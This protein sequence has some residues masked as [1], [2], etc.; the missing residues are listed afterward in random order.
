MSHPARGAWIE[1]ALVE[2]L[3][4]GLRGRTP[5]GV[6]GLKLQGFPY[7]RRAVA[8]HPARG[9]WIETDGPSVDEL[10]SLSHPARG[11]WIETPQ[12]FPRCQQNSCRTPLGVRGLKRQNLSVVRLWPGRTPLGV[13]GLKLRRLRCPVY[14]MQSHPARGAWIETDFEGNYDARW[15]SHPARGAWI[16]TSVLSV[17]NAV[18]GSHPARGA[19]IETGDKLLARVN[20]GVAPRSGCVD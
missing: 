17:I 6:R 8:S 19:W 13:R 20:S 7:L 11:A 16:E 12:E 15:A 3:K 10:R 5:L 14:Q 4:P 9:A 2:M 18:Q 1:T